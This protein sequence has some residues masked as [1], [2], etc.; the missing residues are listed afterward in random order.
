LWSLLYQEDVRVG[1]I[2]PW[3]PQV[4]RKIHSSNIDSSTLTGSVISNDVGAMMNV[5]Q[6]EQID[7]YFKENTEKVLPT[8]L[9]RK[10]GYRLGSCVEMKHVNFTLLEPHLEYLGIGHKD[11]G[12]I[13]LIINDK[14]I[15]KLKAV[16]AIGRRIFPSWVHLPSL[17]PRADNYTLSFCA[18]TSWTP[19]ITHLVSVAP[20]KL[21]NGNST[22]AT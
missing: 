22:Q 20:S 15:G 14:S 6:T 3:E 19:H 5:A 7:T 12:P 2:T 8:R 4:K 18:L 9:D 21:Q 10:W 11:K 1:S 17:V 13:E 16:K